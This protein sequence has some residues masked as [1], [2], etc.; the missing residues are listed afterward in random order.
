VNVE[1]RKGTSAEREAGLE[2]VFEEMSRFGDPFEYYRLAIQ[3]SRTRRHGCGL[4]LARIG[5]E[6][7]MALSRS[8]EDNEVRIVAIA[9][10]AEESR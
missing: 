1:T 8:Y 10:N 4:G 5:S 7:E 6:G 9:T 2:E 3:R